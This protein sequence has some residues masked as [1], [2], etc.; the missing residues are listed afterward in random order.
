MPN[1]KKGVGPEQMA[2]LIGRDRGVKINA[3]VGPKKGMK[4]ADEIDDRKRLNPRSAAKR[5]PPELD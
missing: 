3:T 4:M 2:D 5:I 1:P